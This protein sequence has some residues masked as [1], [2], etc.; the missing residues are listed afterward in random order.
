M[1]IST[2]AKPAFMNVAEDG[3]RLVDVLVGPVLAEAMATQRLRMSKRSWQHIGPVFD[4]TMRGR[5][6]PAG[7]IARCFSIT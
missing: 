7:V 4:R 1:Y 5:R 2:R 3:D 6:R